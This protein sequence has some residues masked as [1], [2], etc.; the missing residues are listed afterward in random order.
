MIIDEINEKDELVSL[1]ICLLCRH[2]VYAN[3][4]HPSWMACQCP[5][6]QLEAV[7]L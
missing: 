7:K 2:N 1:G 5:V 4:Q 6:P 3:K